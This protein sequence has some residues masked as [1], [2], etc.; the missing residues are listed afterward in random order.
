MKGKAPA[1]EI[2]ALRGVVAEVEP[3]DVPGLAAERCIVWM[4]SNE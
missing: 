3:I 4:Q 2:A 1:G